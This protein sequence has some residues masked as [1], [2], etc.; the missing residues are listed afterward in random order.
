[1]QFPFITYG[2]YKRQYNEKTLTLLKY[3]YMRAS[4]ENVAIFT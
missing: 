4:L 3:M 2:M 1:M